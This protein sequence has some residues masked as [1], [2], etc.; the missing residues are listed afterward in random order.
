MRLSLTKP[1]CFFDLEATG[2]QV[3]KD[4][5]I[6]VGIIKLLPDGTE[7]RFEQRIKPGI[8]IPVEISE[9]HGIYDVDLLN[10]PTFEEAADNILEFIGESDLA[11]FNSNKFDVPMLVEE[12]LRVG[13]EFSMEGRRLIDVQ[14]IFHKKE[15]RTLAAAVQFY[16]NRE[17][18]NAHNATADAQATLDVFKAQ[19]DK[20]DDLKD[21]VEFLHEFSVM[22]MPFM[23]LA[24][25]IVK[26]KDG[27]PLFNFGKHK[28]RPVAQV[29]KKEPSYYGWM[30]NGDF[31]LY[32]KQVLT[33]IKESIDA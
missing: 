23:D 14:N 28:G 5:I 2:A 27:T 10:E 1:L 21:D 17:I 12:F 20:Y 9:I 16:C 8:P 33:H 26:G 30:M 4:R 22:G 13:K 6:E 29:L 15:Q 18:E 32:T 24:G 11:G 19:M 25:R 3:G 31:P 7:E